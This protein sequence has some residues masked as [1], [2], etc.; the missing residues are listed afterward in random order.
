L[1]TPVLDPF[2]DDLLFPFVVRSLLKTRAFDMD[3]L[4]NRLGS[5][6]ITNRILDHSPRPRTPPV[7]PSA[8]IFHQ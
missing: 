3:T 7:S 4:S 2:L 5:S 8:F 6:D 1:A